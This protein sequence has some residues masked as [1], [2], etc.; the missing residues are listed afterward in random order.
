[1]K[2]LW[3]RPKGEVTDA[4]YAEFYKHLSHDFSDP[5]ETIAAKMEGT[6]EANV[7]LFVPARRPW[8]A[9]LQGAKR[10]GI[11]LYVKRGLHPGRLPG[12]G[13][14]LPALRAGPWWTPSRCR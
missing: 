13:P 14:R 4:E 3:A 2:A 10:H 1:M 9:M 12:A 11:Q 6:V 8:D 5:L 7:L